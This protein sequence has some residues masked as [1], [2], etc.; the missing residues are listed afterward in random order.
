M[1]L[2][3]FALLGA[4]ALLVGLTAL[5]SDAAA[6]DGWRHG[7]GHHWHGGHWH[8][9]PRYYYARPVVRPHVWYYPAPRAYYV[10]PPPVYYV[11]PAP[12]VVYAPAAPSVGFYFRF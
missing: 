9:P 7:H 6:R 4:G 1:R 2:I 5:P 3:R 12:P 11:P 10:P 8:G